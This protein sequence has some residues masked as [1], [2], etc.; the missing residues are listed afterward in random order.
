MS[1]KMVSE[2]AAGEAG[3]PPETADDRNWHSYGRE[4]WRGKKFLGRAVSVAEAREIV[5][6]LE[7][8]EPSAALASAAPQTATESAPS[9]AAPTPEPQEGTP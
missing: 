7:S 9:P 6:L 5:R 3:A 4:L 1:D 8:S 2:P